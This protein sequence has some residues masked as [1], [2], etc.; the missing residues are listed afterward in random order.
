MIYFVIKFILFEVKKKILKFVGL[1]V[2]LEKYFR[3]I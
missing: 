2:K 1:L 3:S